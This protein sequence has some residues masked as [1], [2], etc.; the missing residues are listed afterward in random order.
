MNQSKN[1]KWL[2]IIEGHSDF[3]NYKKLLI[4]AGVN[5]NDIRLFPTGGK[6]HVCITSNWA[7][8]GKK[9]NDLLNTL[10]NA[11][12]RADF[13]GVI[14][15]LDS[16]TEIGNSFDS[17]DRIQDTVLLYID[18]TPPAIKEIDSSFWELDFINGVN[19]IPIIGI[20]VPF[21]STGCLET[22]LLRTY[23]FPVK[24]QPE[25]ISFDGIIQSASVKWGI[26]KLPGGGNWWDENKDAKIDKFIYSALCEGFNVSDQTPNLSSEPEVIKH[27]KKVIDY[28]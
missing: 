25:Y 10:K 2:I 19:S 23:G 5:E 17:Y 26:P 14:L 7:N 1:Y 27:I 20:N 21:G 15:I 4:K 18:P 22:E 6:S 13:K 24:G 16:D 12:G 11:V 8:I 28:Y 9:G 3:I